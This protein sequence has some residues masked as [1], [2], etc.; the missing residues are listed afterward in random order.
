M[1]ELDGKR[2]LILG[3][4]YLGMRLVRSGIEKGMSVKVVSRNLDT[5]NE[6]RGLGAEV[7]QAMIGEDSWHAFAGGEIEFV[8]NCVSSAG[9]G[10]DG[11]RVSYVDGNESLGRWARRFGF[12]GTAL[13]TSSVSVYGDAEGCWVDETSASEPGT[14]RGALVRESELKFLEGLSEARAIVLRLAGLYGPGRHLM[15]DRLREVPAELPGWGDYFLN[16]VRIEDVVEA[17]WTSMQC[18]SMSSGIYTV[19]DDY[20][21]LKA[22]IVAWL[23]DQ[24]GMKTPRF[25]GSADGAWRGGRRLGESGKPA[26]RRIS[27]RRLKQ[28]CDWSPRFP[29]FREGF[30][31]LMKGDGEG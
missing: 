4:G 19:V 12:R 26:N 17:V 27:N 24:M 8:V 25:A 31:D 3:C 23:S 10:L 9:G 11:Y 28:V 16:L 29:S 2:L 20:P 14:E 1:S 7:F 5:L 13:Y 18:E 30:A 6:A 15:L 21:T 22:E